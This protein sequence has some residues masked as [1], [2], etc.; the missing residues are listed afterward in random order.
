V[1]RVAVIVLTFNGISKL[2]VFFK[3]VESLLRQEG[4][5]EAIFVDNRSKDETLR[6]LKHIYSENPRPRRVLR[7]P[8]NCG[9]SYGNNRG[10]IASRGADYF[11]FVNDDVI[12]ASTTLKK[13]VEFM[14]S[15]SDVE[16]P[17]PATFIRTA[18]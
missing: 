2:R 9:W 8:H 1:S 3:A 15:N 4:D 10:S 5:F 7:L 14:D 12:L 17:Q 16:T 18:K 6:M 13:L 11:F